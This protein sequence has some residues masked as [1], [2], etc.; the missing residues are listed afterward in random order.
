D[1]PAHSS[2]LRIGSAAMTTRGLSSAEFH[3]IG[4]ITGRR[5]G[6]AAAAPLLAEVTSVLSKHPMY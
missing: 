4:G 6:G 1:S 2:G 5:L 3:A